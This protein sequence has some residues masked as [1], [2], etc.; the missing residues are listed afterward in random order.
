M[1]GY[2]I[3]PRPRLRV[4]HERNGMFFDADGSK[5]VKRMTA[6]P[7]CRRSLRQHRLRV[8]LPSEAISL[9][10]VALLSTVMLL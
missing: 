2:N 9:S 1:T 6:T 7:G 8:I 10:S 5:R 4:Y 3:A